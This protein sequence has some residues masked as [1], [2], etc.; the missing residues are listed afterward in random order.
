MRHTDKL[1]SFL[2]SSRCPLQSCWECAHYETELLQD[3]KLKPIPGR[4]PVPA[5]GA[6]L[7]SWR[8]PRASPFEYLSYPKSHV[9]SSFFHFLN[10]Q[11]DCNLCLTNPIPRRTDCPLGPRRCAP[12]ETVHVYQP[13]IFACSGRHGRESIQSVRDGWASDR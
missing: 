4:H 6:G 5:Q 2:E 3:Y 12:T 1:T 8:A 7:A 10:M 13:L 9:N 11:L